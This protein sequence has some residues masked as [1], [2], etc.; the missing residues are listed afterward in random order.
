MLPIAPRT[1][2]SSGTT[3]G[4]PVPSLRQPGMPLAWLLG[5]LAWCG[6]CGEWSAPQPP[7]AEVAAAFL[8]AVRQGQVAA[9]WQETSPDFKSAMGQDRMKAYV[10]SQPVL[11]ESSRLI[12]EDTVKVQG[13]PYQ[14]CLFTP[15]SEKKQVEVLLRAER[16]GVWKVE[17][18]AV[19]DRS[20]E[21]AG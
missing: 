2:R 6:G 8:E 12:L 9:A 20:S 15:A 17:R 4:L 14:R 21:P 19:E 5:M 3:G 18:L 11:R 10:K 1:V 16:S 7:A 13:R